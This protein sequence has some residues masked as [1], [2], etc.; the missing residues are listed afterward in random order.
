MYLIPRYVI[1]QKTSQFLGLSMPYEQSSPINWPSGHHQA[2]LV[3]CPR[4][5]TCHHLVR[6]SLETF[7]AR[8]HMFL[9]MTYL[10]LFPFHHIR[11]KRLATLIQSCSSREG[12]QRILT[13][14]VL[15]SPCRSP[16]PGDAWGRF[17]ALLIYFSSICM[18]K[19][20]ARFPVEYPSVATPVVLASSTF[21]QPYQSQWRLRTRI[22]KK[23][24]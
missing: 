13:C 24:E 3:T 12:R 11:R 1:S 15:K 23:R 21:Y 17:L 6:P 19:S 10:P 2:P 9:F 22:G 7:P 4:L 18:R 5:D 16:F 8:F 20:T 14:R